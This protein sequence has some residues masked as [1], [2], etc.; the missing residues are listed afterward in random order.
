MPQVQNSSP[1]AGTQ[2]TAAQSSTRTNSKPSLPTTTREALTV[3]STNLMII[4]PQTTLLEIFQPP[5]KVLT[6]TI[7]SGMVHRNLFRTSM[8]GGLDLRRDPPNMMGKDPSAMDHLMTEIG[9]S[10]ISTDHRDQVLLMLQSDRVPTLK[11]QPE[12]DR[13]LTGPSGMDLL[14]MDL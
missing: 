12:M 8:V 2:S 11:D 6:N 9:G 3:P 5:S 14:L 4:T 1:S 7:T 10:R 13:T